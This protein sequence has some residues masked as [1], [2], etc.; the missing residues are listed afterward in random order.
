MNTHIFSMKNILTAILCLLTITGNAYA[1][2][3]S[4]PKVKKCLYDFVVPDNGDFAA[5]I[6][7]ANNRKDTAKRFRIFVRQGNYVIPASTTATITGMDDKEYPDPR[8]DLTA[9]NV[10]VIGENMET[11][12]I[13]NTCPEITIDGKWGPACPIEGLRKAYTLHNCGTD[14]YFQDIKFINGMKDHTGRGEAYEES[15]DRTV[16]KNVGLWGYQD[17]YC[18]NRDSARYYFE[19]GVIRGR[20]DYLC[21]KGD[22]L[23]N[24]VEFRQCEKGGYITA[25]S[26]SVKYGYLM[27]NCSVTGETP[28]ID[29]TYTLGRPW[30]KGTPIN[31]WINTKFYV[32]PSAIGWAEMSGGWPARFAEYGSHD[33]Q[34]TI[35]DLSERKTV[36]K[37]KDGDAHENN[38]LLSAEE[39]AAIK[40]E[41]ALLGNDNWKP[42]EIAAD[43][44]MAKNVRIKKGWLLRENNDNTLCWVVCKNGIAW[45]FTTA[46][47]VKIDDDG[48]TYSV[49]A[50]NERGG[51]GREVKAVNRN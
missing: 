27:Y 9:S 28:D 39:V 35:I 48:S 11:T 51:L 17:T 22:I 34:G 36:W 38:P 1:Q 47:K 33:N 32:R 42:M 45:R 50:A 46:P 44:P 20:T 15:G 5:A 25:P 43:A 13:K 4:L 18:S 37:H 8:T 49:R 23:F 6:T 3:S 21:G 10:S 14:N 24:G 12:S 26:R 29:G 7:A 41:T 19:G 2:K 31:L 40:P 16:C 30:G